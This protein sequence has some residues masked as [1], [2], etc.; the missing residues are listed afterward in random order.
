VDC[1]ALDTP[2]CTISVC[3]TGQELG[4]QNTCVVI[5][6]PTNT[7]CDDGKFCTVGDVCDGGTC[8]GEIQNTCGIETSPCEAVI[9]Y[10]DSK[11]CDVAPVNEG[12][13]CTPTNLCQVNGVCHI[14]DCIGEPKNCA[15]SPLY[16]CNTVACDPATG[17]CKGTPDLNKDG[18]PC[19]LTGDLC[20][21]NKICNAGQCGGGNP[22]DCSGF[23]VGCQVGECDPSNGLCGPANAPVGTVCTEGVPECYVGLCGTDGVCLPSSAPNGSACNDHNACTQADQC[24]AFACSGSPVASCAH[25]LLE[26]FEVC[27]NGWTF[28]GD[29]ECGIP[30]NVG[31]PTAHT[32]TG[33]IATQVDGL[34]TVNQSFDSAVADSPPIDLTLAQNPVLSFWAWD[35]TEGSTFDGWNLKVSTDDGKNFTDVTMVTPPYSLSIL[36]QP[37]WGGNHSAEGWQHY[38]ADLKAY[39][40]KTIILRFA[41]DSDGAGVFPGVYID[42]VVVAEP[43]KDPLYITTTS[44]LADVY[45]GMGYAAQMVK[46]GGSSDVEWKLVGGVNAGWLTIDKAT[47]VLSGTATA[48]NVG[49]VSVT[50][51]VNEKLLPSNFDEKTFTFKVNGAAYYT[52]FEGACP[53]GWTLTGDWEC[54]VPTVVG[55][56][57]AFVGTQCLATQIDAPYSHLQKWDNTTATSPDI[58]LTGVASPLVT[59]RMY[60]DTE[61][62]MFDGV[63]L[64]I[65]T[66][67]MNYS[68]VA[69]VM[70]V[71][72]LIVNGKPAWG[73][74]EQ[75]LAWQFMQADLT[76]Y[77]GQIVRLRFAFQS[78]G[79]GGGAGVYIDDI[80]VN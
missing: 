61:G 28:G 22:K 7:A 62:G 71:Y 70:P 75:G 35:H 8:A 42:D 33:V 45:T 54:G 50:V 19:T 67:G 32:G 74:H 15:F 41:F 51:H 23:D 24:E 76:G 38:S 53:D 66:D 63:N 27:P 17:E 77:A 68:I 26:G 57:T 69:N 80:L 6:L 30:A 1:S 25:Y 46:T 21:A 14:G 73:G 39:K 40:G 2:Q 20:N 78:D 10:E 52:S 55:P 48:A 59:F 36:L 44:P 43:Q 49:P 13:A 58:D 31:P 37:A 5:P 29:W 18:A 60:N 12:A 64:Q 11:S 4:P 56:A 9:C 72:P 34:Y 47:G 65:S 3:N 16:E 79:S